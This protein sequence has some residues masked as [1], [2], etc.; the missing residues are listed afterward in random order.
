MDG[1]GYYCI[2][3]KQNSKDT[4][5]HKNLKVH[6]LVAECFLNFYGNNGLVIDHIDRD[7]TNNSVSNLRIVTIKQNAI[8]TKHVVNR[9]VPYSYN[10][11]RNKYCSFRNAH[12]V[13]FIKPDG[14]LSR[15]RLLNDE[16]LK[17]LKSIRYKDRWRYYKDGK[18]T[19]F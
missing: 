9:K 17:F 5:V 14:T 3:D 15:T 6:K 4:G 18:I 7:R 1:S 8:N 12:S 2:H 13:P 10:D 16:E 19:R 11:Q